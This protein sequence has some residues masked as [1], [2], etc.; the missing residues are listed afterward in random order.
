VVKPTIFVKHVIGDSDAG[1]CLGF[2]HNGG[3]DREIVFLQELKNAV[4]ND[5]FIFG[6]MEILAYRGVLPYEFTPQGK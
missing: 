5:L 6:G 4:P 3:L 2:F 1:I